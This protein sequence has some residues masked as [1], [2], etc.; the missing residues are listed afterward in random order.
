MV[1]LECS[2]K[3]GRLRQSATERWAISGEAIRDQVPTSQRTM[4]CVLLLIV[5]PAIV[6]DVI[7]RGT[8]TLPHLPWPT[9]DRKSGQGFSASS[10]SRSRSVDSNATHPPL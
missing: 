4:E 9:K 8:Y 3:T 1:C 5:V 10:T 7:R 2:R 6:R